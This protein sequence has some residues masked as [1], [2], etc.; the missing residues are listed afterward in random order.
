VVVLPIVSGNGR[1][2]DRRHESSRWHMRR[3]DTGHLAGDGETGHGASW[4]RLAPSGYSKN[5]D[6]AERDKRTANH[7]AAIHP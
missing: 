1:H 2:D 7:N 4:L 5:G 6:R 3:I